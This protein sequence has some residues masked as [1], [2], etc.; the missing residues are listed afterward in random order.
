MTRPDWT[1]LSLDDFDLEENILAH[2]IP[3]DT[4]GQQ[5]DPDA[6]H[7][8]FHE[9]T[10][11][12]RATS[13][14]LMQN[15]KTYMEQPA[16]LARC[17]MGRHRR[18]VGGIALPEPGALSVSLADALSKRVTTGREDLR[19]AITATTLSTMLHHSARITFRP[20][21][22]ISSVVKSNKC[23]PNPCTWKR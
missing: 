5:A 21:V 9:Q 14:G 10:K 20:R 8:I 22:A 16:L 6:L 7:E 17:V 1:S 4:P 23:T 11:Q 3:G 2:A 12:H 19:G 18:G 15:I 13:L